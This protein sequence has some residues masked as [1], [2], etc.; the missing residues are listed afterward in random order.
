MS[1]N[2]AKILDKN[3]PQGLWSK[4][5]CTAHHTLFYM[6]VLYLVKLAT[7]FIQIWSFHSPPKSLIKLSDLTIIIVTSGNFQE[8][9]PV[10]LIRK[11]T[12]H[13]CSIAHQY[14]FHTGAQPSTPLVDCLVDDICCSRSDSAPIRRRFRSATSSIGVRYLDTFLH[15]AP[16]FIVHRIR[17]W[18][19]QWPQFVTWARSTT[20]LRAWCAGAL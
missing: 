10:G 11:N 7:I 17:V 5:I 9:L 4:R 3:I 18:T 15:D 12:V 20:V 2:F 13:V 6:F 19:I 1:T 14:S 16:D 8:T